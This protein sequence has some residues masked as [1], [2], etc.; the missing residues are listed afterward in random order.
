MDRYSSTA[1]VLE[2]A[3]G[4][5]QQNTGH[6]AYR[7]F[8]HRGRAD[9]EKHLEEGASQPPKKQTRSQQACKLGQKHRMCLVRRMED[10][11]VVSNVTP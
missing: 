10:A 11:T 1:Q 4:V 7:E 6:A 5:V 9:V 3:F 8:L 2:G